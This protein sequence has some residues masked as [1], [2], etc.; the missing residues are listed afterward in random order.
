MGTLLCDIWEIVTH[1]S[2][3]PFGSAAIN[4]SMSNPLA[5]FFTHPINSLAH[6]LDLGESLI[7]W[8]LFGV[9]SPLLILSPGKVIQCP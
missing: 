5:L 6:W 8:C 7:Y 2:M 9:N 3:G 1:V 4:T